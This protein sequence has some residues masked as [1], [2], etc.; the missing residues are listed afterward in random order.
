M[1]W[2]I[3]P[4][5]LISLIGVAGL[6][7]CIRSAARARRDNLNDEQMKSRLQGLVAIN[8]A[9]LAVSAIGLMTVVIGVLL[10]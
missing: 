8:M 5:A 2:L 4:G 3:W 6:V 1:E 10:G 9:A 7:Y